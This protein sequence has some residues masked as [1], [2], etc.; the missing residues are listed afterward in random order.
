MP[1]LLSDV[2]TEIDGLQVS[3]LE[4]PIFFWALSEHRRIVVAD[5]S[6]LKTLGRR[7]FRRFRGGHGHWNNLQSTLLRLETP[8]RPAAA[9]FGRHVLG[10]VR[11]WKLDQHEI[12]A[13]SEPVMI[14]RPSS[15]GFHLISPVLVPS[16]EHGRELL[17][18]LRDARGA[19]PIEWRHYQ[20]EY[21]DQP[22]DK[23]FL[24]GSSGVRTDLEHELTETFGAAGRARQAFTRPDAVA[25]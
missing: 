2:P 19:R 20:G 16:I 6:D 13:G 25:S 9:V 3:P 21:P 8:G 7:V 22:M 12:V 18:D 5:W 24:S 23:L 4:D 10:Y 1:T 14:A 17:R 11:P 15:R